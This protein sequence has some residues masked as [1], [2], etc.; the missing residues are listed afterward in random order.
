MGRFLEAPADVSAVMRAVDAFVRERRLVRPGKA[1]WDAM[2]R[3]FGRVG[4]HYTTPSRVAVRLVAMGWTIR[5]AADALGLSE[6][7]VRVAV[8]R[9]ARRG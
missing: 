5:G 7:A 8:Q 6:A 9:E 2:R 3:A 4:W 1:Q